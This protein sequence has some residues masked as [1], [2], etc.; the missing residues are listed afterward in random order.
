MEMKYLILDTETTTKNAGNPFTPEN[1]LC[2]ITWA[3]E[4]ESGWVK[5][6]YDDEPHASALE[7][8]QRLVSESDL[9][10]GFNFKFDL[11]WLRRYGI[12]Y[13]NKR[14]WDCQLVA[15]ILSKQSEKF[16]SL[17]GELARHGL[18]SKLG[19][20]VHEYWDNGVD[21]TGI[22]LDELTKYGVTD[23]ELTR[24]LFLKQSELVSGESRAF[25]S[26]VSLCNADLLVTAEMEWN[27][28]LLDVAACL[29]EAEKITEQVRT[30][31]LE[32]RDFFQVDWVN[33]DSP[34]QLSALLFGGTLTRDKRE[35]VGIYKTGAKIG[36]PRYRV[37]SEEHRFHGVVEPLKGTRLAGGAY[38]TSEDHLRSLNAGSKQVRGILDLL[39]RRSKLEKLRGTYYEGLPEL[40]SEMGW[41][42]NYIHGQINHCIARTGRTSSSK[43]NLQNQPPEIDQLIRSRFE[44]GQVVQADAKGLEWVGIVYLS[45]DPVGILEVSEGVDQHLANQE[46]FNLP[47]KRIAK[48][49]VFRL[50]YGGTAYTYT[51]DPD[52]T[53]V[54][55]KESFW[56]DVM[57]QFYQKYKGIEKVHIEWVRTVAEGGNLVTPT[58][59]RFTFDL[60]SRGDWPRTQILN[61][62]VQSLGADLMAIARVSLF[63]RM[64][65]AKLKSVLINTIH[66]S[67]VLD[68]FPEEWYTIHTMLNE[69]FADIPK[70]FEKLFGQTFNLPMKCEVKSLNGEEIKI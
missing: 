51:K 2:I 62:P 29:T 11:H 65:A 49:F 17:D 34:K 31:D 61:Y 43:P 19:S 4:T 30:I 23:A 35:Q 67:I 28:I 26:L 70:N 15:F 3:T 25:R 8:I 53:E 38:S 14:V 69:V 13:S 45:Q 68:I 33:F 50:I 57:D 21:T 18:G 20:V 39:L 47:T 44:G 63:R 16:P 12:D 66:D 42:G 59:R 40:L 9:L 5:V 7:K 1:R 6:D 55:T 48:F 27:G 52:F 56:Q 46:R 10:V 22:P 36:L 54:S 32:L 24:S 64:K 37:V 41:A 60:N 58:G